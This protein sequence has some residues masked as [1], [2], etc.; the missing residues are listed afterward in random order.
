MTGLAVVHD[1]TAPQSHKQCA[2]TLLPAQ[3]RRD[4]GEC[5]DRVV[6]IL[7]ISRDIASR[8]KDALALM[9]KADGELASIGP[10]R[11]AGMI[12]AEVSATYTRTPGLTECREHDPNW[13]PSKA[14]REA[15]K[16]IASLGI[17]KASA[18][19]KAELESTAAKARDVLANL[20]AGKTV[21]NSDALALQG[22]AAAAGIYV[23]V[24]S[25]NRLLVVLAVLV[26][27]L[28]GGLAFAVAGSFEGGQVAP[29]AV[30]VSVAVA[31]PVLPARMVADAK[32]DGPGR[33][34]APEPADKP[35]EPE[36]PAQSGVRVLIPALR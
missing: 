5:A 24:D 26:I 36:I 25:L 7:R 16:S 6:E 18:D 15:C 22:F 29:E 17:E 27:E 3:P 4:R 19:R 28:G 31:L 33:V 9:V 13:R 32:A 12:E 1:S 11:A 23:S 34:S 20:R 30:K 21:A 10:V 35:Q 14:H 8:R 2:A